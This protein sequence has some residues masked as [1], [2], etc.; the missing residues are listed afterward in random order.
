MKKLYLIIF[1][2]TTLRFFTN[3]AG[4]FGLLIHSL[5]LVFTE[6]MLTAIPHPQE[7]H[8]HWKDKQTYY[9][10]VIN[11]KSSSLQSTVR[12]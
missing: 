5:S 3:A 9:Y 1:N 8:H 11:A 2:M 6:S 7:A 4:T 12:L 10:N